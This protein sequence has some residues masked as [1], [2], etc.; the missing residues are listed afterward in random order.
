M[1]SQPVAIPNLKKQHKQGNKNIKKKY[2][3][4]LWQLIYKINQNIGE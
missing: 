3:L 2:L 1:N 4:G